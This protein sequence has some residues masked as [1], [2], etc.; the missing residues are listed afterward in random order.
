MRLEEY[1]RFL[2]TLNESIVVY[3]K[4]HVVW[5]NDKVTRMMKY[6]DPEE[7]IGISPFSFIHPDH[8]IDLQKN[9]ELRTSQP[10]NTSGL[11]KL[12]CKDGSYKAIHANGSVF[13]DGDKPYLVSILRETENL[14][15]HSQTSSMIQHDLLTPLTVAK[16]Y[17]EILMEK[18]KDPED[19]KRFAVMDEN[20]RKM[21]ETVIELINTMKQLNIL[22]HEENEDK[23]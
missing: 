22:V 14:K 3:D 12:R 19:I 9:I 18:A 2:D 4:E 21:E 1:F 23:N 20:C 15:V 8:L 17:M 13:M 16:G 7:I 11:W 5:A 10:Q 6:D